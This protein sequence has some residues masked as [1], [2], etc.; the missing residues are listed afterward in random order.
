M[1]GFG[2]LANACF[3]SSRFI[4]GEGAR[5]GKGEGEKA[6][7]KESPWQSPLDSTPVILNY[8]LLMPNSTALMPLG[9]CPYSNP[10]LPLPKKER[11]RV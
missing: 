3:S 10:Y 7:K 2:Y 4:E 9:I 11:I 5:Q 8:T 1:S 6:Q